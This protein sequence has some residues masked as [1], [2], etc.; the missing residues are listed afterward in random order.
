MLVRVRAGIL[1]EE[2]SLVQVND[3]LPASVLLP[4]IQSSLRALRSHADSWC[5]LDKPRSLYSLRVYPF[6]TH[7]NLPCKA[8]VP[9]D[10][11][12]FL[13]FR[14]EAT[15]EA[16]RMLLREGSLVRLSDQLIDHNE[17]KGKDGKGQ[18]WDK[19]RVRKTERLTGSDTGFETVVEAVLEC[20]S[21]PLAPPRLAGRMSFGSG[22]SGCSIPFHGLKRA[23]YSLLAC[24]FRWN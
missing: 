13:T 11:R 4:A 23:L 18:H 9:L 16:V 17:R 14:G 10:A 15:E 7:L 24:S 2:P 20:I 5:D 1:A 8:P 12:G 22:R 21:K 6:P 3:N 19:Q